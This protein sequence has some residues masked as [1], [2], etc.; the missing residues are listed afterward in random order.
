MLKYYFQTAISIL[1]ISNHNNF[2]VLFDKIASVY[3]ICKNIFTFQHRIWP[4]QE[5]RNVP[6]VSAHFRSI[7]SALQSDFLAGGE[8]GADSKMLCSELTMPKHKSAIKLAKVRLI[9][10]GYFRLNRQ[11]VAALLCSLAVK[12]FPRDCFNNNRNSW[13]MAWDGHWAHTRDWQAY[14]H[15]HRRHPG[16]NIPF[17]KCG[18][19][20]QHHGNRV[21]CRWTIIL[22][23]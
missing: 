3:F 16:D 4:A 23:V 15:Y 17:P 10:I 18:F 2:R 14:H 5:T 19:F 1:L 20:P 11:S 22:Y 12:Y 13:Y 21:N 7:W 6:V 8:G 9:A